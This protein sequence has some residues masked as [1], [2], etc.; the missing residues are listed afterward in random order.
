LRET[1]VI[2]IKPILILKN[3]GDFRNYQRHL[4]SKRGHLVAP[5]EAQTGGR[6]PQAPSY[7]IYHAEVH[8]SEGLYVAYYRKESRAPEERNAVGFRKKNLAV[9]RSP[10]GED[11]PWNTF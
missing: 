11:P 3:R 5:S 10:T 8:H 9:I 7:P 6:I 2:D 1:P 4:G